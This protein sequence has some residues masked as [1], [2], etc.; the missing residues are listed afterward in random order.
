MFETD[1][2]MLYFVGNVVAKHFFR[3]I[4]RIHLRVRTITRMVDHFLCL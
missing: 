4:K 3:L 2:M 1:F